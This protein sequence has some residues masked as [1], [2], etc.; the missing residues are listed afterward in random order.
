MDATN[1]LASSHPYQDPDP[2]PACKGSG[3]EFTRRF[4]YVAEISG[5]S[6]F[7]LF[8]KIEDRRQQLKGP[9]LNSRGLK[10]GHD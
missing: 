8:S 3:A 2:N 1:S 9:W 4:I 5:A 7:R 6:V 10:N